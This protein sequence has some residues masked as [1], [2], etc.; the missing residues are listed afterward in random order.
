M[1]A[2]SQWGSVE[3]RRARVRGLWAGPGKGLGWLFAWR[4][5]LFVFCP[6]YVAS[7]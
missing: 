1:A 2:R 5:G 4:W 3:L 7:T 6:I